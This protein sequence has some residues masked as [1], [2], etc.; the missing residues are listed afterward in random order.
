MPNDGGISERHPF[1]TWV[2]KLSRLLRAASGR[3][4]FPSHITVFHCCRNESIFLSISEADAVSSFLSSP[5]SLGF[6]ITRRND[7]S[8]SR[9]IKHTFSVVPFLFGISLVIRWIPW[10]GS[11]FML[12]DGNILAS[13]EPE[14]RSILKLPMKP[15]NSTSNYRP[16]ISIHFHSFYPIIP[17][18]CFTLLSGSKKSLKWTHRYL[19]ISRVLGNKNSWINRARF[20]LEN[21]KKTVPLNQV[22]VDGSKSSHIFQYS[23][24][25]R[26]GR[27]IDLGSL[28]KKTTL[29]YP[30]FSSFFFL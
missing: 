21:S 14:K 1:L 12:A 10:K 26:C 2:F 13:K 20:I 15:N 18:I 22:I 4:R 11:N 8:I 28:M 9:R 17:N 19:S 25:I 23:T 29:G 3:I 5:L 24:A 6:R 30:I 27:T 16:F 7:C